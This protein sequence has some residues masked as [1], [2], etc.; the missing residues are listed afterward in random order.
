ATVPAARLTTW[1]V[2]LMLAVALYTAAESVLASVSLAT[3]ETLRDNGVRPSH[4]NPP[5]GLSRE[6]LF[7]SPV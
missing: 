1:F 2:W 7:L 6:P 4:H 5:P 3:P